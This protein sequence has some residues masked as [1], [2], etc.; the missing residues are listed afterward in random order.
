MRAFVT[1]ELYCYYLV[2]IQ[3]NRLQEIHNPEMQC[4]T[5]SLRRAIPETLTGAELDSAVQDFHKCVVP[6]LP[7]KKKNFV[8]VMHWYLV[9]TRL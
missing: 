5:D 6:N 7:L 2:L 8:A 1:N 9:L 4:L 3:L